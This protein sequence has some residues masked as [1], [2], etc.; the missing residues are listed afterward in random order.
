MYSWQTDSWPWKYLCTNSGVKL[1]ILLHV[2]SKIALG[3]GLSY[4]KLKYYIQART[5][6]KKLTITLWHLGTDEEK[7]IL[8]GPVKT[9]IL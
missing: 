2:F 5:E 8:I 3:E 6:S 9:K 4:V 1:Y 7:K